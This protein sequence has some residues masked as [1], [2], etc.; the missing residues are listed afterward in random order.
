MTMGT[1][2][3]RLGAALS[4]AWVA[5][6]ET[7]R[8]LTWM[9]VLAEQ[10]GDFRRKARLSVLAAFCRAHA[11]RLLSRLAAMGRGP[12]PVPS[13]SV[14]VGEDF[15]VA[16]RAEAECVD[17]LFERYE[18]I[19]QLA[20]EQCDLSSAWVCDLNRAEC[21]DVARELRA[22]AEPLPRMA[23]VRASCTIIDDPL[24]EA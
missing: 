22:M 4:A 12:L 10:R 8:R 20:R 16:V 3:T 7:G 9:S 23:G 17:R 6:V 24:R 13:E 14:D 18:A 21:R 2:H 15:A 1:R 19:A 11:S 5:E